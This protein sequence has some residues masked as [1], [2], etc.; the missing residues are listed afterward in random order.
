MPS[1]KSGYMQFIFRANF[2][3]L[4]NEISSVEWTEL[5]RSRVILYLRKRTDSLYE[6]SCLLLE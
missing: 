3:G 5:C 2:K 4:V 6:S 1:T